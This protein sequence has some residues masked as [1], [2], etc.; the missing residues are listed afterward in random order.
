MGKAISQGHH[1]RNAPSVFLPGRM[2]YE[3][4]TDLYM[5]NTD[6]PA[7]I[8]MSKED[9]LSVGTDVKTYVKTCENSYRLTV[10]S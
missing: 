1:I 10:V 7:I 2:A 5:G 8:Y 4:D 6:I 9:C 3:F